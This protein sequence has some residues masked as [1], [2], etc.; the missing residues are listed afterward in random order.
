[1]MSQSNVGQD[2]GNAWAAHRSGDQQSAIDG[3]ERTL[4]RQPD[5]V[6]AHYGKGLALRKL[7]RND[8]AIQSF[9]TAL[10]LAQAALIAVRKVSDTSGNLNTSNELGS[11]DDDRYMMLI[12]M[13]KQRLEEL[14]STA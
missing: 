10:E 2:I 3:F 9:Q 7:G 8:D 14:G 4:S 13:L 6:D 5:S 12:R 1:M 11:T